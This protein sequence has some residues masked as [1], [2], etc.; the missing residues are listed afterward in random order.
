MQ[1]QAGSWRVRVL[2]NMIN[3]MRIKSAGTPN[4]GVE[5]AKGPYRLS[6]TADNSYE[7]I[8]AFFWPNR[9]AH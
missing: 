6:G 8:G 3:T 9:R 2:I 5:R 4:E 7:R 1:E